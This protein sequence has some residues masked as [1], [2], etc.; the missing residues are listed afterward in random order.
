[1]KGWTCGT[2]GLRSEVYDPKWEPPTEPDNGIPYAR[3]YLEHDPDV[4]SRR[5]PN[6]PYIQGPNGLTETSQVPGHF[7]KFDT[8][9]ASSYHSAQSTQGYPKWIDPD[10][11]DDEEKD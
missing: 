8:G 5:V 6:E 7:P 2:T 3:S 10:Y 11:G 4:K 9:D 1:L